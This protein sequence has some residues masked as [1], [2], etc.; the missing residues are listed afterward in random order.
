MTIFPSREKPR[1]KLREI[2]PLYYYHF[3]S[4]FTRRLCPCLADHRTQIIHDLSS[5]C[6]L[7]LLSLNFVLYARASLL[8]IAALDSS[9]NRCQIFE[10]CHKMRAIRVIRYN[11][12]AI[13]PPGQI[14]GRQIA[15]LCWISW[16][17]ATI[18]QELIPMNFHDNQ[19][20]RKGTRVMRPYIAQI[21]APTFSREYFFLFH[22]TLRENRPR[23]HI[24]DV[25]SVS[26]SSMKFSL[27]PRRK[28][29]APFSPFYSTI[30]ISQYWT[31]FCVARCMN[32]LLMMLLKFSILSWRF[33]Y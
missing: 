3:P 27:S 31:E 21:P 29:N 15:K 7:Y 14:D 23:H 19:C 24:N 32:Y 4:F 25:P 13:F 30:Y 16:L 26:A 1:S 12:G 11:Y 2:T 22:S 8:G 6:F 5:F 18:T 28:I 17:N 20:R 33:S 10:Y 9:R